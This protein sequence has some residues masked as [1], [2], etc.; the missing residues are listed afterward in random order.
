VL[1]LPCLAEARGDRDRGA[2][3]HGDEQDRR[4]DDVRARVA[5]ERTQHLAEH[6]AEYAPRKMAAV[7]FAAEEREVQHAAPDEHDDEGRDHG[8]DA[9]HR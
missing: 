7:D 6:F 8:R 1:P 3:H 4:A 2:K 9:E 5:E